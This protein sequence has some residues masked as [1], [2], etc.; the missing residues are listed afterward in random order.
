ML[1]VYYFILGYNKKE[2]FFL[3][4]LLNLDIPVLFEKILNV[5]AHR[6]V[7]LFKKSVSV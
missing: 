7:N 4:S 1:I 2:F 3:H 5:V 6:T